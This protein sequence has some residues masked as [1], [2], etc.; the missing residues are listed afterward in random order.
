MRNENPKK[1]SNI[2]LTL[3]SLPLNERIKNYLKREDFQNWENGRYI[4]NLNRI[5]RM[6]D[7]LTRLIYRWEKDGRPH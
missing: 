3:Q 7:H 5:N 2:D 1:D 6:T 4:G